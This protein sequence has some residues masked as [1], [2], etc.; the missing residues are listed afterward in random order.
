[1]SATELLFLCVVQPAIY[2]LAEYLLFTLNGA[3]IDLSGKFSLTVF[4]NNWKERKLNGGCGLLLEK[5]LCVKLSVCMCVC[6]CVCMYV[7]V[8]VCE[9]ERE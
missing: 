7:H 2:I 6:V 8:C 4:T 3:K 5:K 9:R 1:M